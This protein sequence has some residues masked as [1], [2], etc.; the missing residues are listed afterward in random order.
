MKHSIIFLLLVLLALPSCKSTKKHRTVEYK[1]SW[2]S[3]TTH[4]TPDWFVDGK[5]GVY[6]HWG[7]YSVPAFGTEWYPRHMYLENYKGWGE[8]VRPHHETTYG[9]D[10]QYHEFIPQFTAENF[11]AAEWA[12]LFKAAGATWAGPVA[13]HCDNFSMWDSKVNPWNA[14]KMGPG[15][16]LVGELEKAIRAEGL[17]FTTTFHHQWNWAWYPTW[18]GLVDTSSAELQDFY[19]EW[20]SPE[21]FGKYGNDPEHYG[22][23]D[24]FVADWKAKVFEV[25]DTYH[26]DMLWFDSRLNSIPEEERMDVIAHFYNSGEVGGRP[27]VFNYKNKDIAEGAG[28][29]DIE[30]GRLDEKVDYPWLTDDS[31]DWSGWN[32]KINH[33]YKSANHILDGFIDI[34]SKNGCL[35]LNIGP[36]ADGTIPEEVKEGLLSLGAWLNSY[37][38]AI[39]ETRPFVTFGEGPTRLIKGP[40]GGVTD[41]GI[42]YT[43]DDFR[44]TTRGKYLYIIQLAAPDSSEVHVLETFAPEGKG[45]GLDFRSVKLLGSREKINWSME[46]NGLHLQ[47]PENL[48]DDMALVYKVKLK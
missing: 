25:V 22:P 44:F 8:E 39:Y 17:K 19:G 43:A 26:P 21:T 4:P 37:G 45:A 14:A 23:S 6:F 12:A 42:S 9:P 34:V 10:Y 46:E 48:P 35:L 38:E 33:K 5:F 1:A 30:R 47:A 40:H 3:L 20:T 31:W 16:D 41:R 2:E 15:R 24:A 29:I 13:E 27:V 11:D 28:V 18:N 36:K 32:Y 7:V